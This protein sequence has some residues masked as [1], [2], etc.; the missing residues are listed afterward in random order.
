MK[1]FK[2]DICG[3]TENVETCQVPAYRT[4][5]GCDG[6]TI[7]DK[8]KLTTITID[9]CESCRLKMTNIHDMRVMGYGDIA[10]DR[11]PEV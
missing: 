4:F 10:I 6:K 5:D 2:C 8:P 1:L 7:Y 9:I 11:N 3:S